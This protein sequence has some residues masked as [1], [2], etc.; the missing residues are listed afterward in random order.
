MAPAL[1]HVEPALDQLAQCFR[2]ADRLAARRRAPGAPRIRPVQQ[3]LVNAERVALS[4]SKLSSHTVDIGIFVKKVNFCAVT[5]CNLSDSTYI[6]N[7]GAT[8]V[9]DRISPPPQSKEFPYFESR[10]AD[11]RPSRRGGG[12]LTRR[13]LETKGVSEN[14]TAYSGAPVQTK[15]TGDQDFHPDRPA[16]LTGVRGV[17]SFATRGAPLPWRLG[18]T[19]PIF[20][21][22]KMNDTETQ[23]KNL[24]IGE[25]LDLPEYSSWRS[26]SP[27]FGDDELVAF[28]GYPHGW[29]GYWRMYSLGLVSREGQY[30][31]QGCKPNDANG[32]SVPARG[33]DVDAIS[34]ILCDERYSKRFTSRAELIQEEQQ[35]KRDRTERQTQYRKSLT[36]AQDRRR[37]RLAGLESIAGRSDLSNVERAALVGT[38]EGLRSEISHYAKQLTK[39]GS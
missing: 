13:S 31:F 6:Y 15:K 21:G 37:D 23:Y 19:G 24:R 38:I 28:I 14:A 39:T 7:I 30:N 26:L 1:F 25:R 29:G 20:K 22:Y 18:P 33:R 11:K 2:L 5:Y 4:V 17:V 16:S 10:N 36:E 32:D 12:A 3:V 34:E 9:G 27:V 8:D 35:A